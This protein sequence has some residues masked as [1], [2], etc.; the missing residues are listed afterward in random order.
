MILVRFTTVRY[1]REEEGR[2]GRGDQWLLNQRLFDKRDGHRPIECVGLVVGVGAAAAA[3]AQWSF[4][5]GLFYRV[6]KSLK[7]DEY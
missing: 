3:V 5:G 4:I 7:T 2:D 1:F 6:T